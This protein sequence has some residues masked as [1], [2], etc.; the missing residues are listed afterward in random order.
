MLTD[1]Y[2]VNRPQTVLLPF[3]TKG[4][5]M[6]DDNKPLIGDIAEEVPQE[7]ADETPA[8][9]GGSVKKHSGFSS[10]LGFVL[11]AAGSAVG[12]GNLWRFPYLAAK[13]GGGIFLLCYIA[14]AVTIGFTLLVLEIAIGRKTGKSV[15]GAFTSLN[16]KF[17]WFG[18][19]CLFV[20][21]IIV[22]YYSVIGGW[23]V[24]YFFAF[25]GGSDQLLGA[26]ADVAMS[27]EFFNAFISNPWQPI[28][29]FLIFAA[30]TVL[31]VVFGVQKGIER[32]SKILMPLLAIIAVFL[33]IYV[34]C[35]PGALEG[36]KKFFVPDFSEFSFATLL[37]ALGQL[38][39]SMSLAMCIMITYGSYMK[40]SASITKSAR[41]ISICDTCFAIV[42]ALII[43]P[44]IY[45]LTA[46]PGDVMQSSGPSLMFVQ[47]PAVFHTL[48]GGRV[49]GAI[50]FLLVFF[51]ALTSSI[52][53]VEAIVSVLRENLHW[54]RLK[55]CLVVF[56]FII[57]VGSLS[58]LGFGPLSVIS[59]AGMTI[60]DI[61]DYVSNSILMPVVAIIT[62]LL[63]GHFMDTHTL[64]DEIGFRK[65]GGYRKYFLIMVRYIAPICMLAI[66]VCNV[67]QFI[68]P[69]IFKF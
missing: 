60:L 13:Y 48:P 31:I 58:S 30:A 21:V 37:A 44:S 6:D 34:M 65:G 45:A 49:I 54:S 52:S 53:L 27:G 39:Y 20:P 62:C 41:Q 67:L 43:I 1:D 19:M 4:E 69:A 42:S 46:N 16:K 63:T 8:E 28:L 22:P 29:F 25:V 50:F 36:V 40:K 57:V 68:F 26:N 33:M 35:Q 12:L 64:L 10:K 32:I 5:N 18:F 24:R 55:S 66:L 59:I 14:L 47:L 38:F 3:I 9:S 61:L 56:A 15:I 11:A 51:A 7:T 17:K 23:V 2:K